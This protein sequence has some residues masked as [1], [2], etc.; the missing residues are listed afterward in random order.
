MAWI[1]VRNTDAGVA[2]PYAVLEAQALDGYTG[3]LDVGKPTSGSGIVLFNNGQP[4]GPGEYGQATTTLPAIAAY[5]PT[6]G[7]APAHGER[8]GAKNGTWYLRKNRLG[9]RVIGAGA[10]G[11]CNV[12]A[13]PPAK[14][15]YTWTSVKNSDYTANVWEAIPVDTSDGSAPFTITLPEEHE[16]NDRVLVELL[17]D[18]DPT[19]PNVNVTGVGADKIDRSGSPAA[20]WGAGYVEFIWSGDDDVGWA[21]SRIQFNPPKSDYTWTSVQTSNYTANVWEAIPA[22]PSSGSSLTITLPAWADCE[23]NDRVLVAVFSDYTLGTYVEVLPDGTDNING[24][25]RLYTELCDSGIG[26]RSV[27]GT[28]VGGYWEF[29]RSAEETFG[30]VCSRHLIDT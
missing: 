21:S 29:I 19:L 13:D 30:W 9:F 1:K 27:V 12:V 24:V 18:V 28:S 22:R 16:I 14:S 6:N 15:L 7:A 2:P 25:N 26:G 23:V 10:D 5:H 11:A 8:W 17:F 20:Y 3:L 4:I